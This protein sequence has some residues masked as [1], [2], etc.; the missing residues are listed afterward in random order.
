MELKSAIEFIK[1]LSGVEALVQMKKQ[2]HEVERLEQEF[3]RELPAELKEYI[4][5]YAPKGEICFMGVG[6]PIDLYAVDGLGKQ[7]DGY[8][9]NPVSNEPIEGWPDE[10]FMLGSEGGDP[11]V[12][13]LDEQ[14][15]LKM[16]HGMGDWESGEVIA[17]SIGQFLACAGV[18]NQA[19][20]AFE[21]EPILDDDE[22]F[23]LAP[24]AAAWCFPKIKEIARD[25][26]DEWCSV[27]E[28]A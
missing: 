6:N 7:Q 16:E 10:W 13:D 24:K 21:D 2:A 8:N 19:L 9:F 11:I 12:Y 18:M 1:P 25:Y 22:G 28:N 26:Y 15:V 23:C 17:D 5:E 20:T 14:E 3:G 27:F 4:S